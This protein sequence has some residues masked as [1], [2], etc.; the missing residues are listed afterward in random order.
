MPTKATTP[1]SPI[2]RPVSLEPPARSLGSKRSAR[3]T[4]NSGAAAMTI[5]ASDEDTC[6][7]PTAISVN[8]TVISAAATT[9]SHRA[10]PRNVFNTPARHASPS[11]T[12]APITTRT[13]VT[14]AGGSPSSTATLINRY[15]VPHSVE[16]P[17][18]AAHARPLT[19]GSKRR[20]P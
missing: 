18:N 20:T 6:C 9:T 3:N 15:G 17:T 1:A 16:T 7:S 12:A 19:S 8:G 4:T 14:N 10:R 11:S 13:Q 5:A 2:N